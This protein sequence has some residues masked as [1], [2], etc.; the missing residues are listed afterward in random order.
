MGLLDGQVAIVTGGARGQGRAHAL[1]LAAQGAD[2]VVCDIAGP[3]DEVPYP[4]GTLEELNETVAEIEKLGR[5]ALGLQGDMRSTADVTSIVERVIADFGRVDILIANHGAISYAT[6]ETMSDAAWAAILDINLTGAFKIMRAVIPQMKEQ[7]YG[8]IVAISSMA[9]RAGY[10]GLPH[11]VAAKWGI[12]GLVKSAAVELAG[13]GITVN[14]VCPATVGTPFF[15]NDATYRLLR[16]DLEAPTREDLEARMAPRG[17]RRWLE[18]EHVSRTIVYIVADV[19]GV[20]SGQVH[21][22]S[23]GGSAAMN[24]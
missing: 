1:G 7:S 6:V 11:Y 5:R 10:A 24:A 21:E 17:G 15:L 13:T 16:P 12:I 8:R 22:V 2:V 23:M 20:L 9:G 18:P 4:L 3:I 14:A 19:D